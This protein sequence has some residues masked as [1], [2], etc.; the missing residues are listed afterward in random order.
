MNDQITEPLPCPF[1]GW[2]N[3]RVMLAK[4]RSKVC[5]GW[6][7]TYCWCAV[8][9]TRGPAAYSLD[10]EDRGMSCRKCIERW[11]ERK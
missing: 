11:N 2:K 8:C 7:Y 5:K 1:C 10:G 9:S 6:E 4:R 3:I